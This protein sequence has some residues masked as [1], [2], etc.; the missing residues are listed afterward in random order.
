MNISYPS[1]TRLTV[2]MRTSQ[3]LS[4]LALA[5]S[6][7]SGNLGSAER[8]GKAC[9]NRG[10]KANY[11]YEPA[12]HQN[13]VDAGH[14]GKTKNAHSRPASPLSSARPLLPISTNGKC[15]NNGKRCPEGQC[16]S[17]DG[18]CG[19]S[20][21]CCGTGCQLAYGSC[22]SSRSSVLYSPSQAS[23]SP[24]HQPTRYHESTVLDNYV[25]SSSSSLETG[26]HS[27]VGSALSAQ[28]PSLSSITWS[29]I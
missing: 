6:F 26:I 20:R 7:A 14:D 18:Q 17:R 29:F 21:A 12:N 1:T 25:W 28:T 9:R 22:S 27:D 3:V 24:P 4:I 16:C 23:L 2:A 11:Q 15:G 5:I 8:R 19:V 10:H 13:G